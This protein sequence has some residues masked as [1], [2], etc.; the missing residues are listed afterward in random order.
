MTI[1]TWLKKT[2]NQ[3]KTLPY[4]FKSETL[5]DYPPLVAGCQTGWT[6][7]H[8]KSATG[9]ECHP[10]CYARWL[11]VAPAAVGL[12]RMGNRL[13]LLSGLDARWHLASYPRNFTRL[14]EA[15]SWAA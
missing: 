10:L 13:W 2:L 4:E 1:L 14:R 9:A 8:D 11:R 7:A 15:Q 3:E 12:S 5:G 6:S